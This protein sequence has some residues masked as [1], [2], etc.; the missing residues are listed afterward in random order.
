MNVWLVNPFDPLPGGLEPEGRYATLAR[1][2]LAAGHKV[3]WWTSSFSHRFHRFLDLPA[4]RNACQ[5]A[6][7]EVRFLQV[8]P[9]RRNVSFRRVWNHCL[10]SRR[11]L[12]AARALGR[13]PDVV[14][15]SSP[16]PG[17]ALA[18]TRFAGH[19]GVPVVV[20]VQDLWPETFRRVAPA[21]AKPVFDLATWPAHRAARRAYQAADAIVGV[22]DGYVQRAV[23]LGG[24]KAVA[25]TVPLGVDLAAFDAAAEAGACQ[26]FTKPPAE[27]W[28]VYAGSLT[29]SYDCLTILH[30]AEMLRDRND[31]RFFLAGEGELRASIERIVV[32]R[33]LENV[34][35]TGFLDPPACFHLLRQCDIGINSCLGESMILLPNKVFH[36]LS[37][38]LA[39]LNA[40]PGQ[41]SRIISQG[42]CGLDYRAGDACS[43]AAAILEL[44]EDR[45]ELESMRRA[46]RKLAEEVYDRSKLYREYVDL[47][48]RCAGGGASASSLRQAAADGRSQQPGQPQ[49]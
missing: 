37:A 33:R 2:L 12:S 1:M 39:V 27:T 42:R 3:L 10:L 22:A 13:R 9:Y 14:V 26:R 4:A 30:A 7:I 16:P 35:L 18:A 20:D 17:L 24:P 34:R 49:R 44:V 36:F 32:L 5:E 40:I 46:A 21:W 11:F 45:C 25:R 8:P 19:C 43:C 47:I 15:A 31:L 29:R 6:G 38:G 41:C 23:E 28:L 48:E